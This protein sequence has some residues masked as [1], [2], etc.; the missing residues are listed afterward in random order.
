MIKKKFKFLKPKKLL[1]KKAQN[2]FVRE[3]IDS[4]SVYVKTGTK[5]TRLNSV[6][7]NVI[8]KNR[9]QVHILDIFELN[10]S[11]K[12]LIRILFSLKYLKPGYS[13]EFIIYI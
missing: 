8:L 5:T 13:S 9:N 7:S 11:L 10:T 2:C 1:I 4:E 6:K 3:L 12:Q